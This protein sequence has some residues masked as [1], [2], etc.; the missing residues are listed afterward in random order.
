MPKLSDPEDKVPLTFPPAWPYIPLL[1]PAK[2]GSEEGRTGKFWEDG[3]G[4][5]GGRAT[6]LPE[7]GSKQ[8]EHRPHRFQQFSSDGCLVFKIYLINY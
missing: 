5:V 2:K 7:A 8:K 1:E 4:C 3:N 6:F